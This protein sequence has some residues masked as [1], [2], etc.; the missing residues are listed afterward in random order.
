M[1][2]EPPKHELLFCVENPLYTEYLK[3]QFRLEFDRFVQKSELVQRVAENPNRVL[4]AQTDFHDDV[5]LDTLKKMKRVFSETLKIIFLSSDY[6]IQ[7]YATNVVDVFLHYPCSRD[8]IISSLDQLES[9]KKKILVIDDSKLIHKHLCPPLEEE[10]YEVHSAMDGQEG[11][12]KARVIKPDLVITDIEMP[13][14]NGFETTVAIR[15]DPT[16]NNTFIIMSSTLGSASDQKKGFAAGVDDYI[17][18][19][20][21]ISDL[22]SRLKIIFTNELM[23]RENILIIEPDQNI[24]RNMSKTLIKQGFSPRVVPTIKEGIKIIKNSP[25]DLIICESEV[26]DGSAIDLL[27]SLKSLELFH[28]IT[29]VVITDQDNQSDV[30]MVLKA[31]AKG[32]IQKPFTQ[33]NLLANIERVIANHRSDLE[34]NQMLKYVS[35]ASKKMALEKSILGGAESTSRAYKRTAS[36][37]FSDIKE[38][39]ARC[40]KY[41]PKEVVDQIN[42]LFSV[43]TRSIMGSGGDIDKFIGDACM[44]S[45]MEETPERSAAVALKFMSKIRQEINKMNENHPLLKDDPITIR[46]GLN[47]GE[48]ILCDIGA[49][50]ARIDLTMI[51]DTVNLAARLESASKQYGLDNLF[52]AFC[53]SDFTNDLLYRSIDLIKVKGKEKA[54]E[55]F[56]LLGERGKCLPEEL[57][58]VEA[59]TQA[60]NAYRAG[61]FQ[62]AKELFSSSAKL[63]K[64]GSSLNPSTLMLERCEVLLEKSPPS[65]DGVW[66]LDHK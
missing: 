12:E 19:P 33:D 4:I 43:M 32:V 21:N 60:V 1:R 17:T 62:E 30:K 49:S 40:E 38:F 55:V 51:G 37:F 16:I 45:W 8:Q 5:L 65:W 46:M 28:K 63:E 25:Q 50:E 58:L 14:L 66:T 29:L 13:R 47:T 52:S 7:D 9:K 10:G 61:R 44:A 64:K 42:T 59:Y 53:L 18:K 11:L 23:G 48:V 3:S 39:T 56:E 35:N 34:K 41:Q 15:K 6:K 27:N 57:H 31:G 26:S 54:V 36:V 24:S 22:L 20:V 2:S